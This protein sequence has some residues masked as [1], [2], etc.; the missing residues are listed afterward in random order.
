VA[1]TCRRPCGGAIG[2][3]ATPQVSWW[4]RRSRRALR[5]SG[6]FGLQQ[7]PA[8][9]AWPRCWWCGQCSASKGADSAI[10]RTSSMTGWWKDVLGPSAT[11]RWPVGQEAF[12]PSG[13]TRLDVR[14]GAVNLAIVKPSVRQRCPRRSTRSSGEPGLPV[15]AV[16]IR[17]TPFAGRRIGLSRCRIALKWR[18]LHDDG[19]RF[20]EEIRSGA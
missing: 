12:L 3:A 18:V 1:K 19:P 10:W 4:V 14:R 9:R 11:L 16:G 5:A 6:L 2:Q 7:V 20:L 17:A 8:P 13:A 15:E